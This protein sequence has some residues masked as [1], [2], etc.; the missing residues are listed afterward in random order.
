M[1]GRLLT[2][3]A[4]VLVVAGWVAAADPAPKAAAPDAPSNDAQFFG[5]LGYKD[6]ATAAD[7][8]RALVILISEGKEAGADFRASKAYLT[9]RGIL[10]DGWLDKAAPEA[11]TTKG[12]L[13]V[14]IC[15]ALG[16]KGGIWMRLLGP[17]PRLALSECAYFEIMTPGCDYGHVTGGELVGV[18]DRADR[19]RSTG[20]ED[21]VPELK[22]QPSGA[23]EVQK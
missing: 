15:K 20:T 1:Q 7:T 16:F 9:R 23:G 13:A 10:P 5:E 11:P 12:R 18:I 3:A 4:T 6:A 19:M 21:E 22:G 14:L 17:L 2:I 8:A